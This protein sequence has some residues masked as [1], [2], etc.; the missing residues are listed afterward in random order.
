MDKAVPEVVR[1]TDGKFFCCSFL[2]FQKREEQQVSI[3][4][5]R[6]GTESIRVEMFRSLLKPCR[7][8]RCHKISSYALRRRQDRRSLLS[9]RTQIAILICSNLALQ[10]CNKIDTAKVQA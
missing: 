5:N 10:A 8:C 3:S 4:K 6:A 2:H 9:A 7:L 1:G